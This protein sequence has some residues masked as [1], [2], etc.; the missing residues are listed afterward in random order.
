M[1]TVMKGPLAAVLLLLNVEAGA[2]G[3]SHH[4][5]I[6]LDCEAPIF[7]DESPGKD[8]RVGSFQ[9]FSVVASDNTDPE[10]IKLWVDN[11]LLEPKITRQ[12]SGRVLIEGSL[13]EPITQ[14]RVWIK[15]TAYSVDG[16]DQL[17]NWNVF[18]GP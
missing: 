9:T 16:C 3:V 1:N 18:V 4:G 7:F 15:T 11:R 13:K 2:Y 12:R 5:G 17:H 14:G 6:I 8:A 10:T